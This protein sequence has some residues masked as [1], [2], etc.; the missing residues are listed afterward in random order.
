MIAQLYNNRLYGDVDIEGQMGIN[1]DYYFEL[2]PLDIQE[3]YKTKHI[4]LTGEIEGLLKYIDNRVHHGNL[5]KLFWE[6]GVPVN[7][8]RVQL[9]LENVSLLRHCNCAGEKMKKR[10]NI[11]TTI[12]EAIHKRKCLFI[13]H[14]SYCES[15]VLLQHARKE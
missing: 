9:I 8:S 5:Y 10:E 14:S 12:H 7:E 2:L 1:I 11:K 4:T 13:G 6:K 3:R 15:I